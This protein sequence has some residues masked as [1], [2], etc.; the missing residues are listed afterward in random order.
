MLTETDFLGTAEETFKR[1]TTEA[2]RYRPDAG[3]DPSIADRFPFGE[4]I[5]FG[6]ALANAADASFINQ[7]I[8]FRQIA[9][10]DV[11]SLETHNYGW[12]FL[13][14]DVVQLQL[15]DSGYDIPQ[16]GLIISVRERSATSVGE[17][18]TRLE[19]WT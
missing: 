11:L 19:V 4:V 15:S 3:L 9:L 10:R 17:N 5:E 2:Y 7:I 14:G 1:I 16:L 6:S 8:R 18:R 12:Q 13:P